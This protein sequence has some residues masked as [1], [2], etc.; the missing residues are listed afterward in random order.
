VGFL[1]AKVPV[2]PGSLQN[3]PPND[4]NPPDGIGRASK[5]YLAR[6]PAPRRAHERRVS[7]KLV[8]IAVMLLNTRARGRVDRGGIVVRFL[9]PALRALT[10]R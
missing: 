6:A 2:V 8:A 1:D 10:A 4:A 9:T 3:T 7:R 5:L